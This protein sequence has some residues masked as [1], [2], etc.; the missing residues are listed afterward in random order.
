M[1]NLYAI[2]GVETTASTEEIRAAYRS[3]AQRFHPD[4]NP[5]DMA[6][7]QRM[8]EINEAFAVLTAPERR[9]RYDA[10][11]VGTASTNGVTPAHGAGRGPRPYFHGNNWG[12]HEGATAPP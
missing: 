10:T 8:Q 11:L 5:N 7:A 9:H 4:H 6:A 3:L 2:L 1:Q 12:L